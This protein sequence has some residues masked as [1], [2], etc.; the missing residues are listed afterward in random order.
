MAILKIRDFELP[1]S[2]PVSAVV[3]TRTSSAVRASH[4]PHTDQQ[5]PEQIVESRP[6]AELAVEQLSDLMAGRTFRTESSVWRRPWLYE[7]KLGRSS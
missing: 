7:S 2:A 3:R 6:E 1:I 4:T 5:H